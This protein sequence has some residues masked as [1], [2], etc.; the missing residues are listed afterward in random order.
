M[1]NSKLSLLIYFIFLASF[2]AA[3]SN[4]EIGN[5]NK[6]KMLLEL[7]S[8]FLP[9]KGKTTFDGKFNFEITSKCHIYLVKNYFLMQE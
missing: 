4:Q 8:N 7:S 5:I 9:Y 1:K 2:L 6:G 3:Q